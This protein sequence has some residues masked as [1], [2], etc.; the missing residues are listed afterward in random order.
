MPA[1]N[2]SD[3]AIKNIQIKKE[4]IKR[5]NQQIANDIAE[6][7]ASLKP[8]PKVEVLSEDD[9]N[10][11][12]ADLNRLNPDLLAAMSPYKYDKNGKIIGFN[13][14]IMFAK[15]NSLEGL[16]Y[17]R[18]FVNDE[19]I[20]YKKQYILD[21]VEISR[22]DE[23]RILSGF[24]IKGYEVQNGNMIIVGIDAKDAGLYFRKAETQDEIDEIYKLKCIFNLI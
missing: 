14:Q 2:N 13:E 16:G 15:S 9:F 11:K 5:A 4:E 3:L 20:I 6:R 7:Y 24:A 1:N 19:G 23:R 22:I 12:V 21:T 10:A 18:E 8:S 17:L